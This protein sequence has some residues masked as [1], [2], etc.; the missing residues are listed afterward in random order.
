MEGTHGNDEKTGDVR[1]KNRSMAVGQG[2]SDPQTDSVCVSD[3]VSLTNAGKRIPRPKYVRDGYHD[4]DDGCHPDKIHQ[5]KA[6]QE[7]AVEGPVL[8]DAGRGPHKDPVFIFTHADEA[9]G[10]AK[11]VVDFV[12]AIVSAVDG[13][14]FGAG[15]MEGSDRARTRRPQTEALTRPTSS[16]RRGR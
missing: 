11:G 7:D 5:P 14:I 12:V 3:A 10:I 1:G 15:S 2:P 6:A 16:P 13:L 8:N 9:I 4:Q